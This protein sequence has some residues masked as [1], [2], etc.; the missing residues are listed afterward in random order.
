[1]FTSSDAPRVY[2]EDENITLT[3]GH[4]ITIDC[5]IDANPMNLSLIQWYHNE[6]VI[7][8]ESE[9]FEGG[10]SEIVSLAINPTI[11]EDAGNYYC[12]AEN[13]VGEAGASNFINLEVLCK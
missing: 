5:L 9:R 2:I 3:A 13:D 11:P 8:V 10:T 7:N 12:L 1:M 6:N 4:E